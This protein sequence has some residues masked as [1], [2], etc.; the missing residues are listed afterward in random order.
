MVIFLIAILLMLDI[1]KRF[2]TEVSNNS[3]ALYKVSVD[4]TKTVTSRFIGTL[5]TIILMGVWYM[6]KYYIDYVLVCLYG[7]GNV[8]ALVWFMVYKLIMIYVIKGVKIE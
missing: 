8:D 4:C 1:N 2:N 7:L 3:T 5:V 6:H